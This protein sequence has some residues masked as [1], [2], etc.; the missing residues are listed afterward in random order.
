MAKFYCAKCGKS[1]DSGDRFCRYCG[2][3]DIKEEKPQKP[4]DLEIDS[5][6]LVKCNIFES[7]DKSVT[8]PN[9]IK[10]VDRGD[11]YKG[12]FEGCTLL[13]I[14]YPADIDFTSY[15][16][17]GCRVL[18]FTLPK[19]TR[20]LYGPHFGELKLNPSPNSDVAIEL[21]DARI[22]KLVVPSYIRRI[23][24]AYDFNE[25]KPY[26]LFLPNCRIGELILEG[27]PEL[28]ITEHTTSNAHIKVL[29][30]NGTKAQYLKNNCYKFADTVICRDGTLYWY[31][32]KVTSTNVFTDS[33]KDVNMTELKFVTNDNHYTIN[34]IVQYNEPYFGYIKMEGMLSKTFVVSIPDAIRSV[35]IF[36]INSL[37]NKEKKVT[38]YRP[39]YG[40]WIVDYDS[41]FK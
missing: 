5:T 30:Y 14:N 20:Y 21:C 1:L 36:K 39:S 27:T 2:S 37:G 31:N 4:A 32:D 25:K 13:A 12:V 29:K 3:S 11:G 41:L 16:L 34:M 28:Y 8:I 18:N 35:E 40:S 15:S 22:D 19:K 9:K 38:I 24:W 10:K 7:P 23:N 6:T 33:P 17:S 26:E